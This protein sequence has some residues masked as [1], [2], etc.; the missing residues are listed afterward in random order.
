MAADDNARAFHGLL[1]HG[2]E[3][4]VREVGDLSYVQL[5]L[6]VRLGDSPAGSRRMTNLA[7][8]VVYS[9]SGFDLSGW[10]A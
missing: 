5:Q 3:H 4:Q 2:V 8:D 7:D 6:L 9:R 10:P 1:R